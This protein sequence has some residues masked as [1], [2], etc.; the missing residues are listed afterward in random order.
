LFVYSFIQARPYIHGL[1]GGVD[2][3]RLN[4]KAQKQASN[5]VYARELKHAIEAENDPKRKDELEK[6]LS[7][8]KY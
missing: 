7:H 5:Y 3:E 1:V 2:K 8:L 6:E 4:Q